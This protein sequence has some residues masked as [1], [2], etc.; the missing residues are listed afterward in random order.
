MTGADFKKYMSV[1]KKVLDGSLRLVLLQKMGKA[2]VTTDFDEGAL[3]RVL[4]REM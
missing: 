3:N 4:N 2:I 1:D